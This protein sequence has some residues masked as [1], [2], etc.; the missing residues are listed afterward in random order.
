M[1]EVVFYTP[2]DFGP[3]K[4][5]EIMYHPPDVGNVD[6]DEFEFLELKNTGDSTIDLSGIHFMSGIG[7]SAPFGFRV[8]SGEFLVLARNSDEF[9]LRYPGVPLTG[10]F[11][12][13]LSNG[14]ETILL[15]DAFGTP[16]VEVSYGDEL[17]WPEDADGDGRSLVPLDPNPSGDQDDPTVWRT[18]AEVSGSPGRDDPEARP[19]PDCNDNLVRDDVDVGNG[20]S[21]DLNGNLV[22][23]ECE[24]P[25]EPDCNENFFRDDLDISSDR[26]ED[27]NDNSIPD[28][29]DDPPEDDCNDNFIEDRDDVS[30]GTSEDRNGNDV[31]DECEEFPETDC[32]ENFIDDG[33]DIQSGVSEDRNGS[34]IPDE[35]EDA[36]DPDCNDNLIDDSDDIALGGS[37]DVNDNGIPDECDPAGDDCNENN[38]NDQIDV[39]LGVSEDVNLDGIPDECQETEPPSDEI[40]FIRADANRDGRVDVSDAITTLNFVFQGVGVLRCPDATDVNDDGSVDLA[41]PIYSINYFFVSGP[42]PRP[43]FPSEGT[44]PTPDPL[45]P[46]VR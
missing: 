6:G 36:P 29:C 8:R 35:C 46:C 21:N 33:E 37:T 4:I 3:L 34:G 18:S 43:P 1:S 5:T 2:Q 16:I 31:P 26:S 25:P 15:T 39:G 40:R 12:R 19:E 41:D 30:D 24:V 27:R 7:Y 42:P 14:G 9:E 10:V 38:V 44:D 22:P 45:G 17:P 20:T 23:D 32:N 11:E 13:K 28:E